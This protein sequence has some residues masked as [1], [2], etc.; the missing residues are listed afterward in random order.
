MKLSLFCFLFISSSALFS[1]SNFVAFVSDKESNEA[2]VAVNVFIDSLSLGSSSDEKG[3]VE[4]NNIPAGSH[5]ITFSYLGYEEKIIVLNFPQKQ[6]SPMKIFLEHHEEEGDIIIVSATRSSRTIADNPTRVEAISGEELGEKG[7][8]KPGDIRMLLNESTG[9]QTQQTSATS[10]NSSIRIQGLDG[11]YTQILKDGYPLYAGFSGGLS[12]LQIV[13]LDLKQV[14]VIKGSSSTLYGGGA[15]AG[16]VNLVSKTPDDEREINILLNATSAKG[17]DASSYYADK[18][19]KF[20]KSFFVSYNRGEAYDPADIGFSAIPEFE[21][22]TINPKLYYYYN[23][24]TTFQL[25]LNSVIEDRL[26][27]DM[28]FIDDQAKKPNGFFEENK[29]TRFSANIGADHQFSSKSNLNFKHSFSY[30]DRQISIPDFIFSGEQLSSFSEASYAFEN[31][32][33][34]WVFGVNV[35][36]D[37]FTQNKPDSTE[38]VDYNYTTF[39]A[40]AQNIWAISEK[41]NLESG[42]RFDYQNEYGAF[43]LPRLS[44]L[45]KIQQ[46]LSFRLGGGMGYKTA[47]VF[48]EDAERIQFRNVVAI[49][50]DESHAEKSYGLNADLN[51]RTVFLD[52]FGFNINALLFYTRIDDP[53]VLNDNLDGSYSFT[54]RSGYIDTKGLETNIKL[55]YDHLKL[56]IGYTYSDVLQHFGNSTTQFPLVAKHRLN[57]VLMYEKH[58]DFRIGLEAYY[59]S[60][61]KL[62]NGT[63]GN[64]YWIMGL[65]TEKMWDDFSIFLN[66]ENFL[67]T[68]QTKFETIYTGPVNS[69]VFNDIYAP[70][71]GFVI[72]GGIKIN[73]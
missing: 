37:K 42:F 28:Q 5:K 69:P 68:R 67:D 6:N 51:F 43:F 50:P 58:D 62:N 57:N 54:Q 29:T 11:K 65:M 39:G 1:Q 35:W 25:G 61:Q 23:D 72:N 27:G 44:L 64:D 66:F 52:D 24:A 49:D 55:S 7:N 13:P 8:M 30:Y 26:G 53:I 46:D 33:S 18:S 71:D 14:E 32:K 59:F 3:F 19:G 31:G 4:I 73:F 36:T 40:F 20:G 47:S 2:L 70:I 45:I 9:I 10:F 48:T 63:T 41:F 56:F 38:A 60:S 12:L 22:F 15:I 16:L 17:L 21:R 34:E